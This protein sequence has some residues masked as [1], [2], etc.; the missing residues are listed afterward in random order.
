M[1]KFSFF[2]LFFIFLLPAT[3]VLSDNGNNLEL[4]E[5]EAVGTGST[6]LEALNNAWSEAVKLGV[7]MFLIS[8]ST[9]I[10]DT[11]TEQIISNSRGKVD[12]YQE[13]ESNKVDNVW[14]VKI[15]AKIEKVILEETAQ[16]YNTRSTTLTG[17]MVRRQL[18]YGASEKE[19]ELSQLEL[20][21]YFVENYKITDLYQLNELKVSLTNHKINLNTGISINNNKFLE[22]VDN[23]KLMLDQIA[24]E[25][26]VNNYYETKTLDLNREIANNKKGSTIGYG[27]YAYRLRIDELNPILEQYD[28]NLLKDNDCKAVIFIIPDNFSTYTIYK[29]YDKVIVSKLMKIFTRYYSSTFFKAI[30]NIQILNNTNLLDAT[31]LTYFISPLIHYDRH[32]SSNSSNNIETGVIYVKPYFVIHDNEDY[33]KHLNEGTYD[34]E[35]NIPLEVNNLDLLADNVADNIDIKTSLSV[36]FKRQ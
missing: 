24:V 9:L 12:S 17:D 14:T 3:Y 28:L 33:V 32:Y 35:I 4:I 6:K 29:V 13:I 23:L 22:M 27:R 19:R 36:N 10:D 20:L 16:V 18:A 15:R 5:V 11:Y 1:K 21:D 34:Y 2:A 8:K 25:K 30:I 7:G 31:Q 26:E